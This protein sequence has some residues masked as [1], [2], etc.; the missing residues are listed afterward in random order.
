[1]NGGGVKAGEGGSGALFERLLGGGASARV[2]IG[3]GWEEE[4]GIESGVGTHL[5]FWVV[6]GVEEV[7][8]GTVGGGL[9]VILY[10]PPS[11]GNFE[12]RGSKYT[13]LLIRYVVV[14]QL[15]LVWMRGGKSILMIDANSSVFE[16][17]LENK[18]GR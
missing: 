14:A 6:F 3:R 2:A 8:F 13:G 9:E 1:M 12:R 17:L 18:S 10:Q 16:I 11:I 7:D 4:D 5:N 15:N